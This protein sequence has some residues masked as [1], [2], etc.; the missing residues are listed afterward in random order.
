MN[1]SRPPNL[2]DTETI[3]YEI[4]MFRFSAQSFREPCDWDCWR[5]LECF[6]VHFR[7]LIEFFGK[8][9]RGDTLSIFSPEDFWTPENMPSSDDLDRLHQ[10]NL[11]KKYEDRTLERGDRRKDA[12]ISRYLHHCTKERVVSKDWKVS[13]MIEELSPVMKRFEDLLPCKNRPWGDL[14][15]NRSTFLL[16]PEA[17]GTATVSSGRVLFDTSVETKPPT[18]CK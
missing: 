17:Q 6:L 1:P 18:R 4:D 13:A 15:N 7:N 12:T 11:W 14:P 10:E 5:N 8:E 3:L 2:T 16:P 9:K